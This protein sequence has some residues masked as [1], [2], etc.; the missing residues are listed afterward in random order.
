MDD[1]E[2]IYEPISSSASIQIDGTIHHTLHYYITRY[3]QVTWTYNP[4]TLRS[5]PY[6]FKDSVVRVINL[7]VGDPLVMYSLLS[8]STSRMLHVDR[9]SFDIAVDKEHFFMGKA[10][11][12]MRTGIGSETLGPESIE[13]IVLCIMFL[14]SAEA[15]RDNFD[16]ARIHLQ[17]ALRL[18]EPDGVM[19]I[20]DKNLQGQILMSD[21]FL[22][23]VEMRPCLCTH[24]FD[25]G[26]VSS[27]KLTDEE[28]LPFDYANHGLSL[29]DKDSTILPCPLRQYIR[30]ILESYRTHCELDIAAMNPERAFETTHWIAKRN[31]AIRTRLLAAVTVDPRVYAL[32]MS[33]IMWTLLTMNITGT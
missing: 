23:C 1:T 27:L 32:K 33:I 5:E 31:M 3:S 7:A 22:A 17:T 24:D 8:A 16:A 9:R 2:L 14:G 11:Q 12:L 19:K 15:Y 13:Q 25:P 4:D 30:E 28:V 18:L 29:L 6:A 20:T 21:L 26:P 10:L